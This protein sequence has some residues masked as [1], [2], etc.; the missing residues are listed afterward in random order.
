MRFLGFDDEY[1]DTLN[2]SISRTNVTPNKS[3]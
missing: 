2:T 1:L 3:Y